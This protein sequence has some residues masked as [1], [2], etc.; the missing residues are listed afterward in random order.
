[1]KVGG[2]FPITH[3]E[4]SMK[5]AIAVVFVLWSSGA[6]AQ[7]AGT[8]AEV[9]LRHGRDLLAA[10]KVAQACSAFEDSQKLVPVVT[11]LL[12]LAGCLDRLGQL[13]VAPAGVS[14]APPS[15]VARS[16]VPVPDCPPGSSQTSHGVALVL[17]ASALA[18]L[19]GGLGLELGAEA[20]Y[21]AARS[22]MT[23]RPLRDSLYSSANTNRYIAEALAA[24]GL[25][26]GG[27]AV[28]LYVR[29]GDHRPGAASV[30]VLPTANGIA[31]AGR[32]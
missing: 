19:G 31:A 7:P 26:A 1:M 4:E 29:D 28:W 17:G 32:F 18:L 10:K 12:E 16:V 25:A 23:S 8:Q 3:P 2:G 24:G 20:Q 13:A 5:R 22:G 30:H 14:L 6:L 21:N 27:A 15:Q 11:T 9:L